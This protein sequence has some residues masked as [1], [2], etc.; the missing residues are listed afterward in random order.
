MNIA[1][2]SG[3][4]E[5]G[6]GSG[7]GNYTLNQ[8]A[9]MIRI[10]PENDYYYLNIFDHQSKK[11]ASLEAVNFHRVD[12]FVAKD[13][14]LEKDRKSYQAVFGEMIKYF[15][16]ENNIDVFYI[17][18][19]FLECKYP[20]YES[21]WF[22][23]VTV[24]ATAWDVIP[25]I[26][27]GVYLPSKTLMQWYTS[28]IDRLRWA[29][30]L[31]AISQSVKDDIVKFF[32]FDPN[33]IDVIYAGVSSSFHQIS[34][35][36]AERKA[37][38]QKFGVQ[39]EFFL[40]CV[41]ADVR[42]NVQGAVK[43]F[44]ALD[45]NL[46]QRCQLVI[47][48]RQFPEKKEEY[49]ALI[50]S[51][52]MQGRIVLTGYVSDREL[53]I[54]YNLAKLMIIPSLYEGFGLPVVEAWACGTPVAASNNSSLGELVGDAGILFDPNQISDIANALQ[55][56][57]TTADLENLAWRG[58]EKVKAY[59]WENTAKLSIAAIEKAFQL[60]R[61]SAASLPNIALVF[62]EESLSIDGFD[63]F[64]AFLSTRFNVDVFLAGSSKTESHAAFE[65]ARQL[66][67]KKYKRILYI[68]PPVHAPSLKY[69]SQKTAWLIVD[70]T[71]KE[72]LDYIGGAAY[73]KDKRLS[74]AQINRL[75]EYF[76][77]PQKPMLDG[78]LFAG[79]SKIITTNREL[80]KT[81]AVITLRRP[82]YF[83]SPFMELTPSYHYSPDTL[84]EMF[85]DNLSF[86]IM[87]EK[88]WVDG[89]ALI[90][91][92][93][94]DIEK[95]GYTYQ[96]RMELSISLGYAFDASPVKTLSIGDIAAPQTTPSGGRLKV[97]LIT[98]WNTKCGIAEFT[99]HYVESIQDRVQFT[100]YPPEA[101]QLVRDDEPYV[102]R[103]VW[104]YH[105]KL[106]VLAN[107]LINSE[108]PIT[109]IEY[110]EG[111]F[112]ANDLAYLLSR[113]NG[114]KRVLITCHNCTWLRAEDEAER[115]ALNTARYIVHN[116]TE[117]K[118]LIKNGIR[119]QN[120][121][122]GK[123]GQP[124]FP[125]H[126]RREVQRQL[127]LTE[128][129]P[130]LG[131]YGFLLPHKGIYET[132]VAVNILTKQYP[133]ILYI[134][135]CALYPNCPPSD[136]YYKKCQEAITQYGLENHVVMI[137]DFLKP[138]ES[139]YILQACDATVI[140][141]G[142]TQESGSAERAFLRGSRTADADD[143]QRDFFRILRLFLSDHE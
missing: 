100:I 77:K 14:I 52:N 102:Y 126:N 116:E 21:S 57:L 4:I 22:E 33:K 45:H 69:G 40:C 11:T 120:I 66:K 135:C 119:K 13:A 72:L 137:T 127:S 96:E 53:L 138:E 16:R 3:A 29:D 1:F 99:R 133:D 111:F 56:A 97:D 105:H 91:T 8:F 49:E 7:I 78:I 65:D 47:V 20:D 90:S 113:L 79:Y 63:T 50:R 35:S 109:H 58:Q 131:S 18:A 24:I 86:A 87:D 2:D 141:Y 73:D 84:R 92:I 112:R 134:A 62:T 74:A 23:G 95:R 143:A 76:T 64:P 122:L 142:K 130:I 117:I 80:K 44:S 51:L 61:K 42:K 36:E 123:L 81:I 118:K 114:F 70:E 60:R 25:Y 12:I 101:E 140:P 88:L 19:P 39:N 75:S 107:A 106:E 15:I 124:L 5:I 89:D 28:C 125:E 128:Y 31:L 59:T 83:V 103:R 82:V 93:Q 34:V 71:L 115:E 32:N 129:K 67:A 98:S 37:T 132:I 121:Y 27:R 30:R 9:E 104:R 46:T 110:T 6:I 55:K 48:G 108:A 17:T 38:L 54:L 85:L 136:E 68:S 139:V 94:T 43:A 26:M 10:T 41:S